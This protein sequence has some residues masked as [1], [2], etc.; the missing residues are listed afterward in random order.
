MEYI[1]LPKFVT[2]AAVAIVAFLANYIYAML[3]NN[4]EKMRIRSASVELIDK[5]INE[6]DWEKKENRIL[7]EETFEQLYA[8]PLSFYEIK[9]LIYSEYPNAAFRTYLKY[10]PAIE[11]NEYKTKFRFKNGKRPYW[12]PFNA[13]LKI[14]KSVPKGLFLYTVVALPASYAMIWLLGEKASTL[15]IKDI[16]FWWLMD[17]L[18]WLMAMI[19]FFEGIKYQSS[20]KEILRDLGDKFEIELVR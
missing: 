20:E 18:F 6:R 9:I 17:G 4:G 2:S 11:V 19:Y 14:P 13:K 10:R 7:V 1:D 5:V 8:K 3:T 12:L 16:A 15:S